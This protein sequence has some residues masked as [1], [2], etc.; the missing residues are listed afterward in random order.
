MSGRVGKPTGLSSPTEPQS[1]QG[2]GP[3]GFDPSRG[4]E[5]CGG[6]GTVHGMGDDEY[7][8]LA[9]MSWPCERGCKR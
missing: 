8:C 1:S 7:G 4:C 5:R 2:L 6:T 9:F 3:P